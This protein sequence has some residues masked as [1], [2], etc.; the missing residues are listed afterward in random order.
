MITRIIFHSLV[1]FLVVSEMT[2]TG[3]AL[4]KKTARSRVV[5]GIPSKSKSINFTFLS[6]RVNTL[7]TDPSQKEPPIKF[8]LHSHFLGENGGS[9]R[10][11]GPVSLRCAFVNTSARRQ[12]I[13]LADHNDYSGTLP[14]PIGLLARVWDSSGELIT[15]N[16]ISPEG[17]WSWSYNSSAVFFERPGDSI[18]L[19]PKEKVIRIVPLEAVL[20]GCKTLPEGLKPGRYSVQLKLGDL[21]SNKIEITIKSK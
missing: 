12:E 1:L 7:P 19:R 17:W 3:V 20:R 5:L 10:E 6:F 18:T 14:F 16:E 9:Y 2:D 11:G 21:V 15:T 4:G 8:E 13:L